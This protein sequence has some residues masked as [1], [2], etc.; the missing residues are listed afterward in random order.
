MS[1]LY[2]WG[3]QGQFGPFSEGNDGYPHSGEVVRHYRVVVNEIS[4]T[5]FGKLYG[6]ALGEKPK[7]RIWVLQMERTNAV[8][9]DITRRRVIAQILSIPPILLGLSNELAKIPLTVLDTPQTATRLSKQNTLQKHV[10]DEYEQ[11]LGQ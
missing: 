8:P 7:T 6:Q 2:Y 10:L 5:K 1:G 11:S 4:A 3:D 9:L